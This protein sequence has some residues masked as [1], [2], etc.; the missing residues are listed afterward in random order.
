[1]KN[2]LFE[3]KKNGHSININILGVKVKSDSSFADVINLGILLKFCLKK[4]KREKLSKI[5]D[6]HAISLAGFFPNGGAGG[7]SAA[8]SMLKMIYGDSH[9]DIPIRYSFIEENKYGNLRGFMS[10][11]YGAA[12]HTFDKCKNDKNTVYITNDIETAFGLYLLGK[13][14]L[15]MVHCQGSVL[16]EQINFGRETSFVVRQIVRYLE[17]KAVK[18]AVRVSFPSKG[19]SEYFYKSKYTWVKNKD[20][21]LAPILYNTLWAY[22]PATKIDTLEKDVNAITF[23]SVG[24][25]TVAKGMDKTVVFF[26][27]L[28]EKT[29]KKIR[30]IFSGD[31]PLKNSLI[32]KLQSLKENYPNFSYIHIPPG[33]SNE[34]MSYLQEISDIYI[35]LHRISIFDLATLEMMNKAKAVILS[36][37]GGNPEF[38]KENNILLFNNNDYDSLVRDFLKSD[39]K[40]LGKLNKMTY[41]K[42]FSNQEYIKNYRNLINLLLSDILNKENSNA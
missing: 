25:L 32:T 2:K 39:I 6:I 29:D 11:I 4:R 12:Q 33:L 21:I 9:K 36:A 41:D 17:K 37:I 16:E 38:N 30:Y 22:P 14:Y 27:K 34:N 18:N 24:Q 3:I 26:E 10:G 15:L 42:N 13:N 35:M 40:E 20:F 7:P 8:Q 5:E 28:L 19:A 31:G 23:L 1:M